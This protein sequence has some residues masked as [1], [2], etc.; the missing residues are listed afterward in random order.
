MA[1]QLSDLITEAQRRANDS[2]YSSAE[3]TDYL[4]DTIREVSSRHTWPFLEKVVEGPL[5]IGETTYDEQT[6]HDVTLDS[7]LI[8]PDSTTDVS[9]LTYL[10][11]DEFFS[12][13]PNPDA[14]T[15]NRPTHWTTFAG[16]ITFNCPPDQAYVFRQRYYKVPTAL[17]QSSDVP[18]VPERY[19]EVLLR[20]VLSRIEE[21][22]D[23]FDYAA[24]HRNEFENLLEDMAMRLIPRQFGTP[25][26]LRTARTRQYGSI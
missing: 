8:H 6:D 12:I 3:I 13:F 7:Y 21:R 18:T 1:Y 16:N 15:Q 23:N 10:G 14:S 11:H 19:K 2:S 26:Q 17:S 24:I 22:R 4:N 20:G 9:L 5:T 25:G